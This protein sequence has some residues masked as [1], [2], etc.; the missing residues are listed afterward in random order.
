MD[1]LDVN[2][3]SVETYRKV[4]GPVHNFRACTGISVH[5]FKLNNQSIPF[6]PVLCIQLGEKATQKS[7]ISMAYYSVANTLPV[8]WLHNNMRTIISQ[9]E[10][11][12]TEATSTVVSMH[13]L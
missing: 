9:R 12:K 1:K 2:Y 5:H 4:C 8:L 6:L 11:N 13:V 10:K 7:Q 3:H